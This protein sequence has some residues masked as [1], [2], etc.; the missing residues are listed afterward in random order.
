MNSLGQQHQQN[1]FL[2]WECWP[3]GQ[4]IRTTPMAL[5]WL[6]QPPSRVSFPTNSGLA[7]ALLP[8]VCLSSA[9]P[10]ML[11]SLHMLAKCLLRKPTKK[12]LHRPQNSLLSSLYSCLFPQLLSMSCLDVHSLRIHAFPPTLSVQQLAWWDNSS[13]PLVHHQ[14]RTV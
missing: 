10:S 4:E 13:L 11:C 7:I 8:A 9:F 3:T 1:Y 12:L 5:D 14:N 2:Q 6:F